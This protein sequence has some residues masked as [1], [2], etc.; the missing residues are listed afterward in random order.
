M[1][2]FFIVFLLIG[3]YY[4]NAVKVTV[5]KT[6]LST[7]DFLNLTI[8]SE[9]QLSSRQVSINSGGALKVESTSQS[10]SIQ[11]VNGSMTRNFSLLYR[12]SPKKIGKFLLEVNVAGEKKKIEIEVVK[13]K[14]FNQ[15]KGK[16]NNVFIKYI[17]SE[18]NP[19]LNQ[20]VIINQYIY[21][22]A[23]KNAADL[24]II[25]DLSV[26]NVIVEKVKLNE[27]VRMEP[28]THKGLPYQRQ[29][30]AKYLIYPYSLGKIKVDGGLFECKISSEEE[31]HKRIFGGFGFSFG[32]AWRRT[33]FKGNDFI[34]NVKD[35][36]LKNKSENF[37]NNF[38]DLEISYQLS[39]EKMFE[40]QPITLNLIVKG[41]GN[42]KYFTF[43]KVS[44]KN[45]DLAKIRK[46]KKKQNFNVV[47]DSQ[48]GN[49]SIDYY[50]IPNQ[51]G[52]LQINPIDFQFFSAKQ[53]KYK[54]QKISF[55][56]LKIF[57]NKNMR[58][59][60]EPKTSNTDKKVFNFNYIDTQNLYHS[61]TVL[62][63][64]YFA[65]LFF[66]LISILFLIKYLL[67]KRRN[68]SETFSNKIFLKKINF[69][70]KNIN[71]NKLTNSNFVS[72]LEN[73]LLK[74]INFLYND[75]QS[76]LGK[77]VNKYQKNE[78]IKK[79]YND[80]EELQLNTFS[81]EKKK[82]D[83][84]VAVNNFYSDVIKLLKI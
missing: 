78:I 14:Q 72:S 19:Y 39:K 36:P 79:I 6:K 43:P 48:V 50:I 70:I 18:K 5:D 65:N 32:G 64:W 42:L 77:A 45:Q 53:K 55:P 7:L 29:L 17:V 35:Y 9:K 13:N 66:A 30:I 31:E 16:E 44:V 82:I 26:S 84:K 73:L 59:I 51:S 25:N 10:S 4:G 12:L 28:A 3:F 60:P 71:K 68:N 11:I 57:K 46:G 75:N 22:S 58:N 27:T 23:E 76:S 37:E 54:S 62:Y 2:R 67:A 81:S 41:S 24:K 74:S 83:Q 21:I 40:G 38:G 1:V 49:V 15:N 52:Y 80:I 63:I 8:K 34:L 69:E 61:N 47:G 33:R 20:G 56:K